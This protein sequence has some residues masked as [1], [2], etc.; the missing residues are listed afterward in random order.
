MLAAHDAKLD[1]VDANVDAVLVDTAEIGTAGIGLSNLGGMSTAMKAEVQSEVEDGITASEPI[2]AN[3]TQL[4]GVA[5]SLIDLKD[6]ADSGYDPATN[7]VEGVKLVDTTTT[8][9]DMRG[10]N[11][12]ATSAALAAHDGKLDTV[13]ANVDAVLVD[14]GTSGVVVNSNTTNGKAEIQAEVNDALLAYDSNGGVAKESSVSDIQNNTRFVTSIPANFLIPD[15]TPNVYKLVSI[16][17]DADGALEDPDS[18]ELSINLETASGA[19]KNTILYK[20]YAV[21]SP[22]DNSS[23]SG[24][25]KLERE[26]LGVY[27][28]YIKISSTE[29]EAQ[30]MYDFKLTEAT[31]GFT[32]TRSNSVFSESPGTST[33]ADNTTNKQIIAKSLKERDVSGVSAVSGSVYQ[34]INNNIDANETKIDTSISKIDVVDANVDSILVDTAEIGVAGAGLTDLGGMSTAMKAE[35]QLEVEDGLTASE[36]IDANVVQ[37]GGNAQSL[38]DLKDFADDGYDPATNKVEGVKLT[39]TT[40]VNTDMRGTDSA[41]TAASLSTHDSK[42]DVVDANVDDILVDTAEIGVSGYGLS[43][44]GGMSTAMK[45]EVQTEVEDGITTS[46]PID[47]NVTQWNSNAVNTGAT[48]GHPVVDSQAISDSTTAAN[49]VEANI[50]NLNATVSSRAIPGD[51]MGIT[52]AAKNDIVDRNWNEATADHQVAGSTG[53]ALTDAEDNVGPVTLADNTTNKD[54]VA[55]G[56]LSTPANKLDTDANGRVDVSLIEGVDATDQIETYSEIGAIAGITASEPIDA[57]T[58]KWNGSDVSNGT[59][60]G[61]PAVDAQA[62]SNNAAA[63]DNVEANIT[64]L[65]ATVSSRAIPGD[66]MG[67]TTADKNDVVDKVWDETQAD[68]VTAGTTGKSL[69]DARDA[70]GNVTLADNTTNKDIIA[71]S[72]LTTPANTIN[73]DA[74]GRVD[75]SL[76]EGVDATTQLEDAAESGAGTAITSAEPINSNVTNWAGSSVSNGITSGHPV[77]DAQA[78]SDS[79]TAANNVESNITNLDTLVSSRAEPGD[80]MGIANIDK[81]DIV[82]KVWD[83]SQASHVAAGTTGKSL[84]DASSGISGDVTLDDSAANKLIIAEGILSTPANKLDTDADG[85]VDISLIEGID[86]TSQLT[87]AAEIGA[88]NAINSAEPIDSNVVNWAGSAVS[89]G[90]TSGMPVVDSQAIS[91]STTAANNVEANID[92]LDVAVSTRAVPGDEMDIAATTEDNIV[93][94]VWDEA[95]ADHLTAGST[96][97]SLAD[98]ASSAGEVTLAD[99]AANKQIVAEG[100]LETPA[101][102]L[103]TDIDGGVNTTLIEGTDAT[104]QIE[105]S[106]EVG[107][108]AAI[109]SAEPI[110]SNVVNWNGSSVSNGATSGYPVVDAQAISDSTVTANS[111]EANIDNL[112]ATVSSRAIPGDTMD[113]TTAAKDDIVDKTWDEAQADHLTAG[114]T[115]ESL[116]EASQNTG[117][118]TLADNVAN[119]D[120]ISESVLTT[121]ANKLDTD[122]NGRVDVSLIEGTDATDVLETTSETGAT[123]AISISEPIDTNVTHWDS[124]AVSTGTTSGHPVVDAQ[125]ISDSI[126]AA[127]DVEANIDNLDTTVSSRAI[128]GDAMDITTAAK[129]DVVDRTW[130]E[131]Q[132][133]HVTAGTTGKSLAD[134]ASGG[135][136]DVTLADSAANKLI[137]AEGVLE[138]PANKLVTDTDGRVDTS[139]IE[140]VDATDQIENSSQIGAAA[141]ITA[142]E[143]VDANVTNWAGDSVSVGTTS[144]HPV[145][146]AQAIS[147]STTAADNVEVNIGNLNATV[148]SRAIPGDEMSI[149][150]TTEDSIVDK[151]W[152]EAQADHVTVGTTGK[153]LADGAS[154]TGEVTLADNATNKLIVAE[155]VLETPANKLETDVLG[156][157]TLADSVVNKG[158]V[159]EAVLK[160]PANKLETDAGGNVTLADNILNK[161]I[162]AEGVLVTPSNKLAT[163]AIGNVTLSDSTDNNNVISESVLTTPANKLDT[164]TNGRV[165]VSLIEGVDATDQLET[166]THIGA[167]AAITTSEPIDA[168]VTEWNGADV[169]VDATSAL[170]AVDI[171][172]ISGNDVAAVNLKDNI[173][174]LNT[175]ISSRAVAG[176]DMGIIEDDK[177]DIVDKVWDEATSSHVVVG[178]TGEAITDAQLSGDSVTLDNSTINKTIIGS[179]VLVNTVNKLATDAAGGVD[180]SSSDKLDIASNVWDENLTGHN[181]VNSSSV[182]LKAT[183]DDTT[184]ED[185]ASNR[186]LIASS[187]LANSANKLETDADGRVDVSK[188]EGVDAS[189]QLVLSSKD[190]ANLAI[191]ESEPIDA[192]VETWD[193]VAVSNSPTSSLPNV[194]SEAISDDTVAATSVV[195]NI[196]FLDTSVSSRAVAGDDMELSDTVKDDIVDKVWDEQLNGHLLAG[197]TGEAL[198]GAGGEGKTDWTSSEKTQIRD[199]LGIDGVK[200]AST[201]G[202]IN[203]IENKVDTVDGKIGTPKSIDGGAATLSGNINKIVDNNDGDDFDASTDSLKII[204]ESQLNLTSNE[205]AQF[206]AALGMDDSGTAP[207]D[208]DIQEII[209]IV[210]AMQTI[211]NAIPNDGAM[212][213]IAQEATLGTPSV[214]IAEDIA[215]VLLGVTESN[216]ELTDATTGLA[217]LL[218]AIEKVPSDTMS[219]IVDGSVDLESAMKKILAYCSGNIVRVGTTYQ[220]KDQAGASDVMTMVGDSTTRTRQ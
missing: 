51:D 3:V 135:G 157:T 133:D 78:I 44:L 56:V 211:I 141:A 190:G 194:N 20:E 116:N 81:D 60:S 93:D 207:A 162:V 77:V 62:I 197:S 204:R 125:A 192:N 25:K 6:F 153:S 122:A 164:D 103:A 213:S 75:V 189:S 159:A 200:T 114:S 168:N 76:I 166:S 154:S 107:A 137:I 155:S 65:N 73:T 178:S 149:S 146:D 63:A 33:L 68:H 14:T 71:E 83:E 167:S 106:S 210:T 127:D 186:S 131:A 195:T 36:P 181:I 22:L 206:K 66:D 109:N 27:Y 152:D 18:N 11:S 15:T 28:C 217:A 42:L 95:Q 174:N 188:I 21:T 13:D 187:V 8:N 120:I 160:T 80:D 147:D 119:K 16:F 175:T 90:T 101:N 156:H 218:T 173:S 216:D 70:V 99:N 43:N 212:T 9:T 144:G 34:D 198:D 31:V 89:N 58:T 121:P 17:Y 170:P 53:K 35:V 151:V 130:D 136:G 7:K 94:K 82:N 182:I 115:G 30:L 50:A 85:R 196:D 172:A 48:S 184:L 54:V 105:S 104:D 150:T 165:D 180:I 45:A 128:A 102:K 46:E 5:Q 49:N 24:F 19:D 205:L 74:S 158:V 215:T 96:G 145:V 161:D 57:N 108:A 37:L 176:D 10:T 112:D 219:S 185:N 126:G 140:G 220:Y 163:D 143:P 88:E 124:S 12:A 110:D 52:T 203:N 100:V 142:A 55:D 138:T 98:G 1:T 118:V 59:V 171:G 26:E 2:D 29:T 208:G 38:I 202:V 47:A 209:T 69:D 129:D 113:I 148:S 139:L 193:G 91:D 64:N 32:Y 39:D 84:L 92:S 23:I 41:A 117:N 201:G 132:T 111:V 191:D 40:T 169:H 123:N 199:S 87:D 134:G 79:T 72:V 214:T 183:G 97:K 4:G 61:L 177:N 67:I 179:G 86:A